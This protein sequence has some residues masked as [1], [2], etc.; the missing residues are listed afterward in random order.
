[1]SLRWLLFLSL[2]GS[3]LSRFFSFRA[4]ARA[5]VCAAISVSCTFALPAWPCGAFSVFAT[6]CFDVSV[7]GL[8][9]SLRV[10]GD[11]CKNMFIIS[12][13]PVLERFVGRYS[14]QLT[15]SYRFL[16]PAME[17]HGG[18]A[19][20]VTSWYAISCAGCSPHRKTDSVD[21]MHFPCPC[22]GPGSFRTRLRFG[23]TRR[24]SWW[25]LAA[26]LSLPSTHGVPWCLSLL[27][28]S[29]NAMMSDG[30]RPHCEP[31]SEGSFNDQ[32]DLPT[33]CAQ[34]IGWRPG[35]TCCLHSCSSLG[36]HCRV[37]GR[38]SMVDARRFSSFAAENS[39]EL[40]T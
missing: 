15:V 21:L 33:F 38:R 24:V 16:S 30:S 36:S 26:F 13:R 22:P 9:L 37:H 32:Q 3:S 1:M 14:D 19:Y 40:V 10:R 6:F 23:A 5:C 35:P 11:E 4:C 17:C 7:P 27:P 28:A 12:D 34:R 39:F 20:C 2:R 8:T 31:D 25:S 29:W 18:R